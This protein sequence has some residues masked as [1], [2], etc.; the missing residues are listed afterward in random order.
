MAGGANIILSMELFEL[1]LLL[2]AC[3]AASSVLDQVISKM[4]LPLLQIAVGFIAALAMPH[5][6]EVHLDSE[7]FLVL[8][9]APLLFREAMETD[10]MTLWRNK[11]SVISMAIALVIVSVIA[12]GF[13]LKA[14]LSF[15]VD[16]KHSSLYEN[17]LCF[18]IG[19]E[20]NVLLIF[21]KSSA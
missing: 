12:A 6:A 9:I 4:S 10:K 13:V 21:V 15:N 14:S 2:L 5:L 7:L 18:S 3:V 19:I 16:A 17:K 20:K 11:W 1:V 8:F